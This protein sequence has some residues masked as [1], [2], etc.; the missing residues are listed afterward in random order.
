MDFRHVD[1]E[2]DIFIKMFKNSELELGGRME[3]MLQIWGSSG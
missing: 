2:V 1:F 3:L